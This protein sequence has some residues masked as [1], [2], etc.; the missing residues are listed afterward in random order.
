MNLE[1]QVCSLELSKK[2]L[3]LGVKQ[4][5]Y[6]V[7]YGFENPLKAIF[8]ESDIDIWRIGTSKDCSKGGA[9]WVYTAFTAAE[10]GDLL[11]NGVVTQ[12][13]QPFNCF[14]IKISK[15]ISFDNEK[16]IRNFIINYESDTCEM[17]GKQGFLPRK[18]TKNIYD[19]NLANAMAKMLIYLIENGHI[20]HEK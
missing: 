19:P 5:S 16:T 2:L 6:F 4:D 1:D 17:S 14:R 15:F 18:L 12:N 10:L 7:W 8:T 20:E 13:D 3:T 9:D 11:P